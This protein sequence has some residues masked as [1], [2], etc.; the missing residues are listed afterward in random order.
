M[1]RATQTRRAYA[2]RVIRDVRD[3]RRDLWVPEHIARE[4]YACGALELA[5]VRDA[6]W[7]YFAPSGEWQPRIRAKYTQYGVT[8]RGA[9]A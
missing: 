1:P 5:Q 7:D 2:V 9:I 8:M 6:T 3:A 4:A